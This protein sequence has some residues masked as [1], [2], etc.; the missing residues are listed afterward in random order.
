M[1]GDRR[2]KSIF[3]ME[4]E[5]SVSGAN[6]CVEPESTQLFEHGQE[7]SA[8][9]HSDPDALNEQRFRE[10]YPQYFKPAV[11]ERERFQEIS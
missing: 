1:L 9:L 5:E 7:W 10:Q 6:S 4:D 3:Y 11:H 8:A 2:S